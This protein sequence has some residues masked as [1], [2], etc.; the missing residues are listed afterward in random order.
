M[1]EG[2]PLQIEESVLIK[3]DLDTVWNTFSDLSC[4]K[5][6]NRIAQDVSPDRG[7]M[8]EGER[9]SFCLRPFD[10]PVTI[11]P[12]IDEV[13]PRERVVW[14]GEKYGLRSR[15]EFLF[16]RA[17]NGVLVTS[18]ESFGGPALLFGKRLFPEK[19]VRDLTIAMLRQL[20]DA[21]EGARKT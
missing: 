12:V 7:P 10:V 20:K 11:E 2:A 13:T 19:I 6:W 14:S 18:R 1:R 17:A 4:W 15:H 9:F 5:D 21:V 3:A 16:Q 8:Q